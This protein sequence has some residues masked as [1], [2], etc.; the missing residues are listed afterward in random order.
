MT[1]TRKVF[2]S[3]AFMLLIATAG[4]EAAVVNAASCSRNDVAAAVNAASNN[5]TVQIPAGTC[6]WTS[7]LTITKSITMTGAGIDSTV[8]LDNVPRGVWP[9]DGRILE[10]SLVNASFRLTQLTFQG[11]P[12]ITTQAYSGTVVVSGNP[13]A[14]RIDHV[15]F[16]NLLNKAIRS[17]GTPFGV[18]DH[19]TFNTTFNQCIHVSHHAWG[20]VGAYGDNS[21]AQPTNLGSGQ[22]VFIED[23]T[24][25]LSGALSAV[26]DNDAGGR[27][28]VRYNTFN[29]GAVATHGTESPG[30][31]RSARSF[32][33]Y[34]NIFT[35]PPSW[36]FAAVYLRGGTGVIFNN[37]FTGFSQAVLAANYRSNQA[38][39]VWGMCDG[40]NAF[41]GNQGPQTG[42]PCVDQVGRGAGTMLSGD[43]PTPQAWTRN[44]LEPVYVWGNTMNGSGVGSQNAVIQVG[45]DLMVDVPMPGYAPFRYP[46]PLV[47]DRGLPS[48]PSSMIL[49]H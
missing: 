19:N 17:W 9:D 1:T 30:R 16:Q 3:A 41:D 15:K 5:D 20:G 33:V 43:P 24:F 26:I 34:N 25:T 4:V 21:W 37:T 36:G 7:R 28:V 48:P 42:Y 38:W 18:I 29:S 14:F 8:I 11:G 46:H 22:A 49:I 13:P 32:E 47:S 31:N 35:Y 40:T 45:R 23:N 27:M 12:S 44:A 39:N 2:I 10:F 6:S